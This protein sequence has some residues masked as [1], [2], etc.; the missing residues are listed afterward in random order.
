M[1]A[2]DEMSKCQGPFHN[3][4]RGIFIMRQRV[5]FLLLLLIS[6]FFCDASLATPKTL[7]TILEYI[8]NKERVFIL[9]GLL[10][11]NDTQDCDLFL[12]LDYSIIINASLTNPTTKENMME[13]LEFFYKKYKK[14]QNPQFER[15]AQWYDGTISRMEPE[16]DE[17]PRSN[18]RKNYLRKRSI[19][20]NHLFEQMNDPRQINK[21]V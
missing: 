5:S 9:L 19:Q 8:D 20:L 17:R 1:C 4:S 21:W 14:L 13:A 7:D 12:G 10:H 2:S 16:D 18:G 11:S 6:L 3:E 15:F